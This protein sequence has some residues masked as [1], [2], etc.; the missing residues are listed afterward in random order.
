MR[1]VRRRR[2]GASQVNEE[3]SLGQGGLSLTGARAVQ[4]E[5]TTGAAAVRLFTEALPRE[6]MVKPIQQEESM[7]LL[8]LPALNE[9]SSVFS[10]S[11]RRCGRFALHK[12]T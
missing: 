7:L 1:A 12:Y 5:R 3:L 10:G 2:P 6:Q 4:N 9:P 8:T 11:A